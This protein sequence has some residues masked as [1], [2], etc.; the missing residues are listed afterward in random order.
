MSGVARAGRSAYLSSPAY[1]LGRPR[2]VE[3]LP[4]LKASP[5][6]AT[7]L[8][9]GKH[10]ARWFLE[11]EDP[12]ELAFRA[13]GD[14]LAAYPPGAKAVDAVILASDSFEH[15]AGR[16]ARVGR[17]LAELG[18][19]RAYPCSVSLSECANMIAGLRVAKGLVA[20]GESDRVLVVSADLVGQVSPSTR[21]VASDIGVMSDGAAACLVDADGSEGFL[22]VSAAQAA[23]ARLLES[24]GG[25]DHA[26]ML[27]RVLGH[28]T[29]FDGLYGGTGT[30]A[31]AARALFPNNFLPAVLEAFLLDNGFSGAQIYMDN[32]PR[33][34]HCLSSDGIINLADYCRR[35]AVAAGDEF[36]LL[37]SG[38]SQ[39]GAVLLR[40]VAPMEP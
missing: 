6:L 14:A 39:W 4:E 32:I 8:T 38:P 2:P 5:A 30:R 3:E 37:G 15:S 21:I 24:R 26:D 40:A 20:G 10:G 1:A 22:M 9:R 7:R 17:F 34:G 12:W 31:Q 11:A 18:L 33:V 29:L 35:N 25:S 19:A 13:A 27:A 28:R 23:D 36:V 16:A